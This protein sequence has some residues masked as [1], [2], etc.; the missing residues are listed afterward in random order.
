MSTNKDKLIREAFEL[1]TKI[2]YGKFHADWFN[3]PEWV[4]DQP[5]PSLRPNAPFCHK[6][7]THIK[8]IK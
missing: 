6:N 2:G 4:R 3:D 1:W 7:L 5:D 8:Y